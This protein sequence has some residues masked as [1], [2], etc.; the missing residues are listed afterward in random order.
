[1][2]SNVIECAEPQHLLQVF[3]VVNA[4]DS[5]KVLSDSVGRYCQLLDSIHCHPTLSRRIAIR[6]VSVSFIG[7]HLLHDWNR[8]DTAEYLFN[9][10]ELTTGTAHLVD[11]LSSSVA[12]LKSR[13]PYAPVRVLW[14]L[15]DTQP[16]DPAIHNCMDS[17]HAI[18]GDQ[19]NKVY[20]NE[21][22]TTEELMQLL[23]NWFYKEGW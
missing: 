22:E 18:L 19:M 21:M 3:L 14:M 11:D 9:P 5:M 7:V 10:I 23:S 1:M 20:L 2:K 16:V 12:G 6:A 13:W 4:T 8:A 15:N 17:C